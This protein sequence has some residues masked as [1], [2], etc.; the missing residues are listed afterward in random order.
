MNR[1]TGSLSWN[2]PRSYNDMSATPVIGLVIEKMRQIVSS[3]TGALALAVEL[4]ERAEVA[5]LAVPRH[6]HLRSRR[7]C[8]RRCSDS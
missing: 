3:G 4:S 5:D 2:W 6:H 7:A 8:P 1:A